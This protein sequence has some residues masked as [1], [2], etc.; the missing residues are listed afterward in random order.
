MAAAIATSSLPPICPSLRRAAAE[1][2]PVVAAWTVPLL[3][4]PP[5][6]ASIV[7]AALATIVPDVSTDPPLSATVPPDIFEPAV[8]ENLSPADISRAP[9]AAMVPLLAASRVATNVAE[10]PASEPL[11]SIESRRNCL[12][13]RC[14]QQ[15]PIR[16]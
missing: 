5:A 10:A 8:A 14:W 16:R 13:C 9:S 12:H 2:M 11:L 7:S 15:P 3:D 4:R 1:R 6:A